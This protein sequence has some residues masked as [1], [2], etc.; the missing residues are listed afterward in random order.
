[1][2]ESSVKKFKEALISIGPIYIIVI[3]LNL[4]LDFE[5]ADMIKFMVSGFFL[6]I[7]MWLF[8]FGASIS[9][10]L[11]GENLGKFLMKKRNILLIMVV[12]FIIGAATTIA[13]PDLKILASQMQSIPNV[14]FIGTVSVGVGICLLI[15]SLR[16]LYKID[17]SKILIVGYSIVFILIIFVSKDFVPLAFDSSGVT[18][19]SITVPFIMTFGLGLAAIRSDKGAKEDSFGLVGLSSIGPIITVLILSL[20]YN[21]NST[22]TLVT[23]DLSILN[24]FISTLLAYSKEVLSSLTPI[25]LVAIIFQLTTKN[26]KSERIKVLVIGFLLSFIGLTLFLT[27]ANV[28]FMNIGYQ[29]GI[30]MASSSYKYLL[31]PLGM[32]IGFFIVLAEPAVN[33]LTVKV[34][35]ITSGSISRKLMQF[36]LSIGVSFAVG[37]GLFRSMSGISILYFIIPGFLFALIMTFFVPKLFTAIAFDSG[38]ACSGPLSATLLFPISIGACLAVG[39]NIIS[40]AFG[41]IALVSMFPIITVQLLGL[42][43]KIKLKFEI[44]KALDETI[45]DYSWEE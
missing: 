23:S 38:G 8:T 35:E 33:L 15:S 16:T 29:I 7:G 26:I 24:Q 41:I 19:G 27:G 4:I 22:Y 18:T 40:D 21:T 5:N 30:Y 34:E 36:S 1:M 13:E 14:V 25:I 37:L 11:L 44:N 39:G 20:F 45:I 12:S 17:F 28:G 42:I 10:N 31:L 43:Y 3:I 2:Q 6:I 9:M 32:L